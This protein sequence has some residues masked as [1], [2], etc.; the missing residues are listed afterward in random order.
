MQPT[1][2]MVPKE[3]R[4]NQ[5]ETASCLCALVAWRFPC[6]LAMTR[7]GEL[8]QRQYFCHHADIICHPNSSYVT[9]KPYETSACGCNNDTIFHKKEQ[10]SRFLP[11]AYVAWQR[12]S[13]GDAAKI[14][15]WRHWWIHHFS[16]IKVRFCVTVHYRYHRIKYYDCIIKW[17][18]GIACD[19]CASL[20]FKIKLKTALSLVH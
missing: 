12:R 1:A 2:D 4:L 3:C 19:W 10:F 5:S 13:L 18:S 20:V 17:C 16:C 6:S 7:D 11:S 14:A 15:R 9:T 8:I